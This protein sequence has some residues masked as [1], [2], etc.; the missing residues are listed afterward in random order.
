MKATDYKTFKQGVIEDL[1]SKNNSKYYLSAGYLW[2]RLTNKQV[3]DLRESLRSLGLGT[4]TDD[5]L[6]VNTCWLLKNN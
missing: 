6:L 1:T 2:L 4:E 5:G 3:D